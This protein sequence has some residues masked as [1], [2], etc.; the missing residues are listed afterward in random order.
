MI[1]TKP[2]SSGTS[3]TPMNKMNNTEPCPCGSSHSFANCC[4]PII[5]HDSARSPETLMRSRYTAYVRGYW[6]YLHSS[7]HPDTRPSSVSPTFTDWIGL[8]IIN[9]EH[10]RVEF[11][12]LFREGSTTMV[13]H[14]ISRFQKVAGHWRYLDG[15][16][17][18]TEAASQK[19]IDRNKL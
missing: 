19:E 17:D 4:E 18:I 7:W 9:A 3:L 8:K 13:L 2:T 11:T 6:D 15:Q 12:A 1:S 5:K 10:D 16:C 14:E